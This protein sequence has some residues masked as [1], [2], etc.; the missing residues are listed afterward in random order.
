MNLV[1]KNYMSQTLYRLISQKCIHLEKNYANLQ[2]KTTIHREQIVQ[3]HYNKSCK[4]IGNIYV[5]LNYRN[6]QNMHKLYT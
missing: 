3:T 6:S 1:Y 4:V 5:K 2:N